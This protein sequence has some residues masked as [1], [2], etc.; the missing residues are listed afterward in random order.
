MYIN[1]LTF[2]ESIQNSDLMELKNAGFQLTTTIEG[3]Q[4][5]VRVCKPCK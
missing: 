3:K 2:Y 1:R 5:Y 4:L